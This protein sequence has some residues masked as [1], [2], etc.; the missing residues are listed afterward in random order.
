MDFAVKEGLFK[1]MTDTTFEPNTPM[2]R[3]MLVT[4]LWRYEKEPTAGRNTFSDVKAGDW[5]EKAAAWAK[6]AYGWAVAEK[7]ITGIS[8][9]LDP[10]GNATRAQVATILM[11]YIKS[12]AKSEF[13]IV[14]N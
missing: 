9:R 6:D 10:Q 7:L 14:S 13:T 8:G 2:T 1:G 3:G 5:Y 11:R 4:V 12:I